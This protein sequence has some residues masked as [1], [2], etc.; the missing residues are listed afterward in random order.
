MTMWTMK[1]TFKLTLRK[2][3]AGTIADN[4]DPAVTVSFGAAT[5]AAAEGARR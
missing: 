3:D 4:D 1:E 5:Y 2:G